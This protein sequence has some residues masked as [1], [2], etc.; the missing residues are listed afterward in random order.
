M[1]STGP[2]TLGQVKT[3]SLAVAQVDSYTFTGAVGNIVRVAVGGIYD[4]WQNPVADLIA[5]GGAVV[6]SVNEFTQ[7]SFTLTATGTY[8]VQVHD[9]N[10]AETLAYSVGLEGV[11]PVSTDAVAIGRGSVHTGTTTTGAQVDEVT[12]SGTAGDIVRV[13]VAG[14]YDGWQNPVADLIAPSGAVVGSVNEF[15][16]SPFTLPATGTYI[17]QVHDE[18]YTEALTY[19][20]GLE[21]VKPISDDARAIIPSVTFSGT[22]ITGAQVDQAKFYADAGD[23]VRVAVGLNYDGW[24]N[25]VGDILDA[26][27]NIV[28]SVTEG[29]QANFT[30][31]T[32]GVYVIQFHDENFSEP[33]AYS[34]SLSWVSPAEGSISGQVFNDLNGN[35]TKDAGETGLQGRALFLDTNG[36]TILDAGER[37]TVSDFQGNY[38]FTSLSAATYVVREVV[39]SGWVI[40]K[41]AATYYSVPVSIL[42]NVVTKDFGNKQSTVVLPTLSIVA[43][44]AT[45]TEP[46][47]SSTTAT[48]TGLYTITRTG[49]TTAALSVILSITGTATNGTD[50]TTITTPVSI[51]AGAAST[52]VK[53]TPKYDGVAE[54]TETAIV[55][56]G[57]SA[58]YTID[59]AKKAATVNIINTNPVTTAPEADVLFGTAA[60]VDGDTSP[61]TTDGTDFGSVAVGATG[62]TKV[63]TVKNTG[64]AALTTSNLRILTTNDPAGTATGVF[65]IVEGLSASIA[66][67]ASDTFT[68]RL[69]TTST[70]DFTRYVFFT[71]NDSNENPYNFAIKGVVAASTGSIAGLLF[72]DFNGSSTQ[73]TGDSVLGGWTVFLDKDNDGILDTGEPSKLTD[74]NGGYSFTALTNGAYRVRPVLK[75]GWLNVSSVYTDVTVAGAAIT[76]RNFAIARPVTISGNVFNDTNRDGFQDIGETGLSAWKLFIDADNDGVLYAGE[77]TATTDASGNYAFT[78]LKPG[79]FSV[80]LIVNA[81]ATATTPVVASIALRSGTTSSGNGFGAKTA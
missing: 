12:F 35:A 48:D 49:A 57:T 63:F 21:G 77:K 26:S 53:L 81:G 37:T 14:I 15:T 17:I 28:G 13:A 56:L 23:V 19:S 1:L 75:S 72:H 24:Q 66:P 29:T 79:T 38:C 33:L 76:A 61:S 5:P 20:V 25:P 69:N 80:R 62:P 78:G 40:T 74:A 10:Y 58:A 8:I 60:V 41:P 42:E 7:S 22:L 65:S 32:S 30:L 70:G 2:I 73:D 59:A 34:G 3:G 36:N 51:P 6:G 55:T 18:N 39:P 64:T 47:S 50:Y 11:K 4:G 68:I 67:G 43:T 9:E 44:D 71:N 31:N 27:M 46:V 52:T 16:Q 45:A 54:S